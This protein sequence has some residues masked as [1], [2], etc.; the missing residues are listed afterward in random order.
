MRKPGVLFAL[1]VSAISFALLAA[2]RALKFGLDG[3]TEAALWIAAASAAAYAVLRVSDPDPATDV[4][5]V[6]AKLGRLMGAIPGLDGMS[7]RARGGAVLGLT[8]ITLSGALLWPNLPSG[9]LWP[10]TASGLATASID[11][12]PPAALEGR[13]AAL[14]G[15]T[16]KLSGETLLLDGIEAPEMDQV[17]RRPGGSW[18]CGEAAKQELADKLRGKRVTCARVG[19]TAEGMARATCETGGED[20]AKALVAKGVVFSDK[21][22]FA[23]YADAEAAA[24]EKRVGVWAGEN[25]RRASIAQSVGMRQNGKPPKAAQSKAACVREIALTCCLGRRPTTQF[26]STRAKVSVGSV[27]RMR[28]SLPAGAN[29]RASETAAVS[30][31]PSNTPVRPRLGGQSRAQG[32][33]ASLGGGG[34]TPRSGDFIPQQI[35]RTFK[36]KNKWR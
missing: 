35:A 12:A 18:R 16:I 36:R 3:D 17:C 32:I 4:P 26:A 31:S 11:K 20:V 25:D 6:S 24:K 22:L 19:T 5:S 27:L 8:A 28:R 30:C 33:V 34:S 7:D 13:A 2:V 1:K 21:G 9:S 29:P 14:T 10:S 23:A 15:S